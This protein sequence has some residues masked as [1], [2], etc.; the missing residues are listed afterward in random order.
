MDENLLASCGDDRCVFFYDLRQQHSTSC[1]QAHSKEVNT[2]QF[3]PFERFLFVTAS[4]DNTL[5]LWDHRNVSTP[6]HVLRGHK[7]EIFSVTWNPV[8]RN[9][10]A[11][12]GVDRRVYLWDLNRVWVGGNCEVDWKDTSSGTSRRRT[13]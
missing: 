7:A 6:L 5:A 9:I 8:N 12:A 1:L 3:H 10:L 13:C 2:I 4:S 11:S